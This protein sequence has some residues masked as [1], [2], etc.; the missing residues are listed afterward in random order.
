MTL[1]WYSQYSQYSRYSLMYRLTTSIMNTHKR[2]TIKYTSYSLSLGFIKKLCISNVSEFSNSGPHSGRFWNVELTS[3]YSSKL[4]KFLLM[5]TN[6]LL[7]IWT[8]PRWLMFS[9]LIRHWRTGA[10]GLRF[11]FYEELVGNQK[12]PRSISHSG[13]LV[14]KPHKVLTMSPFSPPLPLPTIH[15]P[16]PPPQTIKDIF[17]GKGFHQ[18]PSP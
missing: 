14:Y 6:V 5:K 3:Y 15:P 2:S 12:G 17:S 16:T 13:D 9:P 7:R 18:R 8:R 10:D 1:M 4:G 11:F